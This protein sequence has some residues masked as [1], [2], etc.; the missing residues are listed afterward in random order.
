MLLNV[1]EHTPLDSS[2]P[3]RWTRPIL[4]VMACIGLLSRPSAA[5]AQG[6][7]SPFVEPFDGTKLSDAWTPVTSAGG[8]IEVKDGWATFVAPEGRVSH[9]QRAG[10]GDLI[11]VSGRMARWAGIYLVWGPDDWCGV[12]KISPTPFGR[13]SSLAVCDGKPSEADHRGID[14]NAPHLVRIRLGKDHIA[15]QYQLDGKWTDLRKIERPERFAEAPKFVAAGFFYGPEDRPFGAA[16]VTAT[17]GEERSGAIDEF[18]VEPTPESE[19]RLT[20]AELEAIRRPPPEPVNALLKR[21][22]ADP[23]YEEIVGHYPPFHYPRSRRGARASAR[24]RGR[25]ARPARHQPVGAAQG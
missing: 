17:G 10:G 16:E 6:I 23:T 19:W 13:F 24:H 12:G 22:D 3:G 21:G 7:Q 15:F 25:L 20:A 9:A 2:P 4:A 8:R 11:S 14:F 1:A 5:V 18:R